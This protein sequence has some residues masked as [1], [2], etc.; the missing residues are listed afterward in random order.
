MKLLPEP[1][2]SNL[3]E[4]GTVTI[5]EKWWPDCGLKYIL[6]DN[7]EKSLLEIDFSPPPF[8]ILNPDVPAER[9]DN[10]WQCGGLAVIATVVLLFLTPI[11][12]GQELLDAPKPNPVHRFYDKPAK[13]ELGAAVTMASADSAITCHNLANGGH[14][15]WMTQSCAGNVAILFG[16]VAVQEGLAYGFHRLGWHKPE[17]VIRFFTIQ[18]SS[19]AIAYSAR[20]GGI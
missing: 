2:S 9:G 16:G 6:H 13:I 5:V 12:L 19:R 14:E 18:A 8:V 3:P 10:C 11:C 1:D 17:R 7:G 15:D 4:Q 20:H